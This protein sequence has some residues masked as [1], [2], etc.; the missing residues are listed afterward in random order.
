MA[1]SPPSF[2]A[3]LLSVG[4]QSRLCL[5]RK[6]RGGGRKANSNASK[7]AWPSLLILIPSCDYQARSH[8]HGLKICVK[9]N[10]LNLNSTK[11]KT[12]HSDRTCFYLFLI[13]YIVFI[14]HVSTLIFWPARNQLEI[15]IYT[16]YRT[17]QCR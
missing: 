14:G 10:K 8:Q 9:S 5:V 4:C 1:A 17:V 15:I 12:M 6:Q 3:F 7:E 13:T 16:L 11:N 2:Q